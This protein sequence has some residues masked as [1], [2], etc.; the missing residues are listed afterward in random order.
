MVVGHEKGEVLDQADR[1]VVLLFPFQ[2]AAYLFLA[3]AA[4][5]YSRDVL[6][7]DLGFVVALIQA[8]VDHLCPFLQAGHLL[9]LVGR[10]YLLYCF[11]PCSLFSL[12]SS[13][14]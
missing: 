14:L 8:V 7:E 3:L 13:Q 9:S 5:L 1:L 6:V 10:P 12:R 2:V 4:V 11:M